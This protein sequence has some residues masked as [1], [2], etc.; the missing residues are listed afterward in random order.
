[1]RVLVVGGGVAGLA[2]ALA[3][4]RS[5]ASVTVVE[6]SGRLGLDQAALAH[7]LSD[8]L[9]LEMLYLADALDLSR[10]FGIEVKV[11]A[12]VLS[13]DSGS[14]AVRTAEG[15][16]SYD[17]LVLATGSRYVVD[18]VKG[19]SKLGVYAMRSPADYIELSRSKRG[20]SHVAIAGS[21]PL[22]LVV[23]QAMSR[24][25]NARVFLGPRGLHR[26]SPGIE[27]MV[28]QAATRRVE[29]F[30]SDVSAVVGTG[31]VEAVISEGRVYPCDAV[32]VLPRSL[33]NLPE[34]D[35]AVGGHGG[36]LVDSSMRTSSGDIFAAGDCAELR[37][38]SASFPSRLRSSSRVMGEVAG[39]NAAGVV[40]KAA[41]A[42]SMAV[43]IFGVEVMTAGIDL[44]E[45]LRAGLDVAR[46][47]SE[48]GARCDAGPVASIV[49]ERSNLRVHGIQVAGP[50]ALSLSEYVS[51]AVSSGVSLQQLAYPES[52]YLPSFNKDKPPIALT[53]GKALGQAQR[54]IEAQGT[55]LRYR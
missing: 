47:D 37:L 7:F 46:V 10:E 24:N 12:R 23:A 43:D 40:A 4:R 30:N 33:P 35:C 48:E 6:G 19:L 21:A 9:P 51:L 25:S 31:R 14:H 44:E 29:L 39:L 26:F 53:A 16:Q 1:V 18:D 15:R 17:S 28:V 32:V 45:G 42:R 55:H 13:I 2:A 5:G 38:G 27:R 49:Y 34:V 22:S 41:L 11:D 54:R 36:L 52:P 50:G 8:A 20:L 3:A